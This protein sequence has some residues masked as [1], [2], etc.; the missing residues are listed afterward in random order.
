VCTPELVWVTV[1]FEEFGKKYLW[2]IQDSVPAFVS[3][4]WKNMPGGMSWYL[5]SECF[6]ELIN[7]LLLPVISSQFICRPVSSLF[8]QIIKSIIRTQSHHFN[9]IHPFIR[10]FCK[11]NF[12]NT[13]PIGQYIL[14]LPSPQ[15][16]RYRPP[17]FNADMRPL[18]LDTTTSIAH[19]IT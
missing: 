13:F 6:A 19:S 7:P 16:F 2:L 10:Y 1:N 5:V 3:W 14:V 4:E 15:V 9:L 17:I 12:N 18:P 11:I 8:H